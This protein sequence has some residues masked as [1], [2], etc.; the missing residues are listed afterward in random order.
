MIFSFIAEHVA[1][2]AVGLMCRVCAY[3]DQGYYAWRVRPP[4]RRQLEDAVLGSGYYWN[5]FTR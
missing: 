1:E 2:H 3:P 5:E 4:R